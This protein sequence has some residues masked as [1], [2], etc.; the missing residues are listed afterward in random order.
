M[1]DVNAVAFH[2]AGHA[3]VALALGSKV[4]V[5]EIGPRPHA[6][7]AHRTEANKAIVALAGDLA[8][9]RAC[10]LSPWGADVDFRVAFD[11]A[12]HL[13][14]SAPHQAL[15]AFRDQAR[16]LLDRHWRAVEAVAAALLDAGKLTGDEID[17]L[18]A[19]PRR[20][21]LAAK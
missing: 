14:P 13:A 15:E 3:V 2:E 6:H 10:P 20:L 4:R 9:R 5:V 16:A 21:P 19:R 1:A 17:A 12:E 18:F 11:A 7:C 8:E